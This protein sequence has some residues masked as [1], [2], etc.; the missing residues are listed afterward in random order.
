MQEKLE[1]TS[2]WAIWAEQHAQYISAADQ[3]GGK[4]MYH[5]IK[6]DQSLLS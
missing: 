2:L 5:Y 1:K 3:P 6:R 4:R